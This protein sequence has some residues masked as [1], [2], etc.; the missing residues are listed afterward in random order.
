MRPV[1][2]ADLE[3]DQPMFQLWLSIRL[4]FR[5]RLANLHLARAEQNA[6]VV[7]NNELV[8]EHAAPE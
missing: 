5:E 6:L 2:P 4:G 1:T 3:G 7:L 8:F